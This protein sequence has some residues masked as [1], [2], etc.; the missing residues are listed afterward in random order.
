[1]HLICSLECPESL[2]RDAGSIIS[3][4]K[5]IVCPCRFLAQETTERP[6]FNQR[7]SEREGGYNKLWPGGYFM[8]R[9]RGDSAFHCKLSL[10]GHSNRWDGEQAK[11]ARRKRG[12]SI[13][14]EQ[15]SSCPCDLPVT[16]TGFKQGDFNRSDVQ[17]TLK[18]A[19]KTSSKRNGNSWGWKV[20]IKGEG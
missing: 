11:I 9:A 6:A 17:Q 14:H 13:P 5:M 7:Y 12:L 1:M 4:S 15:I 16:S 10:T 19:G 8:L 2:N 20:C 3:I 18:D